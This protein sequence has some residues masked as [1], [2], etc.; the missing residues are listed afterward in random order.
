MLSIPLAQPIE[1]RLMNN[2]LTRFTS[3]ALAERRQHL[4]NMQVEFPLRWIE[5][6]VIETRVKAGPVS[7]YVCRLTFSADRSPGW[8]TMSLLLK[9]DDEEIEL[10]PVLIA[11][12]R[13]LPKDSIEIA[14]ESLNERGKF[15]TVLPG[16]RLVSMPFERIKTIILTLHEF[17]KNH[18]SKDGTK[19]KVSAVL[20]FR[21]R[22]LAKQR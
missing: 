2:L 7:G 22:T 4:H 6:N 17:L 18:A 21:R 3:E 5:K 16:G 8:F 1:R 19:V 9:I 12:V 13:S 20:N 14:V 10:M 11:A 15:F